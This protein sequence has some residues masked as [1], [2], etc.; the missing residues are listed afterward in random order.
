MAKQQIIVTVPDATDLELLPDP[1]K[2]LF[3]HIQLEAPTGWTMPGTRVFNDRRAVHLQTAATPA[4][5]EWFVTVLNGAG[6]FGWTV[7]A[8]QEFSLTQQIG[9]D[10]EPT[11]EVTGVYK[12]VPLTFVDYLADEY[13]NTDPDNPI[14]VRPDGPRPLHVFSGADAWIWEPE[15]S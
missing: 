11:G 7:E 14:P 13:D 12:Q 4:T 10:G 6:D 8:A 1:I 2:E 3:G 9:E 15:V 5:V